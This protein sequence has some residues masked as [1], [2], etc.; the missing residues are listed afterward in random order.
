MGITADAFTEIMRVECISED[1]FHIVKGFKYK[2]YEAEEGLGG[3][4]F[5]RRRSGTFGLSNRD[6]VKSM[7]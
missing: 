1:I 4:L 5:S 6:L 7:Y 3:F 2:L